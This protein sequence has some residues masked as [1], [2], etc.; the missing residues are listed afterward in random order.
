MSIIGE[1]F[2]RLVVVSAGSRA[3]Q[4]IC[5]CD[6]G[7]QKE[8]AKGNLTAGRTKSCGCLR[9]ERPNGTTHGSTGTLTHRRWLSMRRRCLDSS[10]PYYP[11]YGGRGI[12][13]CAR[14]DQFENFLSDMGE[15]P[16]PAM[17]LDRIDS[18]GNYEP[19]NCRWATSK[20]QCRNT[21]K[22]RLLTLNGETM[23]VADWA[24]RTGIKAQAI[25]N[26][27]RYGWTVERAL[28]QTRDG[29]ENNGRKLEG[30]QIAIP[31]HSN[32]GNV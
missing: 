17:T 29:R 24:E 32:R 26:R 16:S 8:A 2:G 9:K 25:L 19:A 12:T 3:G 11:N 5:Q 22:N 7:N 6:C 31:V 30:D 1:R 15:C 4:W 14:W 18:N 28:T 13:V 21:R 27:L 10:Q 23:C 20:Q